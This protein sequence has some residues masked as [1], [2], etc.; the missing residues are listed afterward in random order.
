M[1]AMA[2]PRSPVNTA[3]VPC[4]W[5]AATSWACT[6][7]ALAAPEVDTST[8]TTSSPCPLSSATT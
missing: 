5:L 4:G 2:V 6:W 3:A 1:A 7:A 8:D